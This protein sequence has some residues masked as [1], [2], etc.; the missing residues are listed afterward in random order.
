VVSGE[1]EVANCAVFAYVFGGFELLSFVCPKE[2]KKGTL[3][4]LLRMRSEASAQQPGIT[5]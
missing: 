4:Q 2:S 3:L 1:Y 5:G